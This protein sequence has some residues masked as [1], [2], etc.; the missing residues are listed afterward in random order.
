MANKLE[1][2]KIGKGNNTNQY[3]MVHTRI[4]EFRKLYPTGS[5]LTEILS[6]ENGMVVIRSQ[7]IVDGQILATGHAYEKEGSSFINKQSYIENCETS[8][9]GRCL[10]ILGIGIE[11]GLAS[12]EEV[13]NAKLNQS[14]TPKALSED[15]VSFLADKLP[16]AEEKVK[17]EI[18]QMLHSSHR[19]QLRDKTDAI[20]SK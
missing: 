6:H 12:E 7:A 16:N 13:K 9:V 3:V 4:I 18:W 20:A 19:D 2:V 5:I 15:A 17:K 11:N 14:E 10:G 1:S 8:S